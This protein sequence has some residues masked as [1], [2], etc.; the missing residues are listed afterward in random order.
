MEQLVNMETFESRELFNKAEQF[1]RKGYYRDAKALVSEALR[2]SPDNP[3]YMSTMGLCMGMQGNLID[4]EN[5]CRKALS[6]SDTRDPLLFVNLGK[7]LLEQGERMEARTFF[8]K[9]YAIDNTSSPAALELSRM[10]VRKRPVLSFLGRSH[11][12]NIQLGKIRH[13]IR[14]MRNKGLKKL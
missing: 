3:L 14:M 1:I 4:G 13:Q 12:L 2:I 6:L 7:I 10:G 8:S 5:M 9:A 11:P